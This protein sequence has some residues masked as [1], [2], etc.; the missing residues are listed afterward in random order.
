MKKLFSLLSMLCMSMVV[1]AQGSLLATLSHDGEIS[2]YYG[3]KALSSALDAA[4]DGDVITLSSGT[5]NA[6]DITKSVT[7]RGAGMEVD[8][9]T[10][11]APTII[12]GDFTINGTNKL[13]LEGF[14]HNQTLYYTNTVKN[15][16]FL[17]CRFNEIDGKDDF[18]LENANFIHCRITGLLYLGEESSASCLN[19]I[20]TDPI[21]HSKTTSNFEI[22]NCIVRFTSM[23]DN[24]WNSES[25]Q[26]RSP[27]HVFSS[28]L[29]N[30]FIEYNN[31]FG[32]TWYT[33]RFPSSTTLFYNVSN[34][35]HAFDNSTN[36]TN[37]V[38]N[39]DGLF[40]TFK[41]TY[42]DTETFE[43]NN[44]AKSTFLGS[45]GKE[46]GI[47]GGSLPYS[48]IPSNPRITKCEVAAKS[49]A[50]GKL[51]VDIVVNGAE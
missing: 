2:A 7:I 40:K 32:N 3:A 9:I 11:T 41:G 13:V 31:N 18:Y 20:I 51:S 47:Y 37:K 6:C 45:D 29:S 17:K 46:I 22:V 21:S 16:M 30:C 10:A 36:T 43:L 33:G 28:S 48:A 25:L 50:D 12:S 1:F 44:D 42:T 8:S 35:T 5:F 34:H 14:F 4:V 19:S 26:K 15:P 23:Q 49:T 27:S 39:Y 24:V 38:S